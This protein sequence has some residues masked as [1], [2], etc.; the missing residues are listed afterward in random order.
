MSNVAWEAK[1]TSQDWAQV[2]EVDI[3]IQ[4]SELWPCFCVQLPR[5]GMGPGDRRI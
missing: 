4:C 1:E 5:L 2:N 3:T